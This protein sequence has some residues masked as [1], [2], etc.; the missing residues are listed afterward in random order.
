MGYS[1]EISGLTMTNSGSSN[2]DKFKQSELYSLIRNSSNGSE[3]TLSVSGERLLY[4][5]TG[6]NDNGPYCIGYIHPSIT[7]P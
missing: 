4:D 3:L 1:E 2:T 5:V 6:G 7:F